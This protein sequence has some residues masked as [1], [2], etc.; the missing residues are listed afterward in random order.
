[1]RFEEEENTTRFDV[2]LDLM[3]DIHEEELRES[4]CVSVT[5]SGSA[6]IYTQ[7]NYIHSNKTTGKY[8][9]IS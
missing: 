9:S 8:I 3:V 2:I 4:M 1:M 5:I 6:N 7:I